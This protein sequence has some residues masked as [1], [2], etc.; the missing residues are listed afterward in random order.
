MPK[1]VGHNCFQCSKLS[2]AEAQAKPCWD[3]VRCPNRRHYQRNKA[4]I[5]QQRSQSRP[6]ESSGNVPRTI[7]IE[8]P[9][10]TA[11]SIIFYRERQDAPVHALAAQVWQGT[12]KVLKVEPMHCLGLS[13]AQVVEVMT[14][15]LKACSSELGVELTKFASKVELHPS[16]CP[17]SSC[18]QWHHNN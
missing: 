4:R 15:I 12:E 1:K 11:I 14:E 7:V 9:I 5:S 13:P 10:G 2:T 18:P 16:Q 6:V 3:T 8:P 17:I